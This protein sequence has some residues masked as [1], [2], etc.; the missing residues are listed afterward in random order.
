MK[1]ILPTSNPNTELL[2]LGYLC[3]KDLTSLTEKVDALDRFSLSGAEI[4]TICGVAIQ[5]VKDARQ[6]N[7]KR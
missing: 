5:S 3:V 2:M 1:E 4:A 6:K 7:K